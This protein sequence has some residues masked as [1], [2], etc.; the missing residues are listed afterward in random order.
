MFL[1]IVAIF[2]PL[3]AIAMIPKI[4]KKYS[5]G[6]G[7]GKLL[8][9][10]GALGVG[11]MA[12]N[13]LRGSKGFQTA[14][15]TMATDSDSRLRRA[16][17]KSGLAL[18]GKNSFGLG[19]KIN[20]QQLANEKRSPEQKK[21]LLESLKQQ[22]SKEY[23][24][25]LERR[26]REKVHA[27]DIA[28]K[29]H[30]LN[31]LGSKLPDEIA[32]P[33]RPVT[34]ELIKKMKKSP[35]YGLAVLK[36]LAETGQEDVGQALILHLSKDEDG[37]IAL[38]NIANEG[39][40]HNPSL[41]KS[42]YI[43]L[44]GA[45]QDTEKPDRIE[46][47]DLQTTA[48]KVQEAIE[49]MS[50]NGVASNKKTFEWMSKEQSLKDIPDNVLITIL[51]DKTQYA[52]LNAKQIKALE[53]AFSDQRNIE[54]AQAMR[55]GREYR[56]SNTITI[57]RPG[58]SSQDLVVPHY[59]RAEVDLG[60]GT[61]V[62][63]DF[64][65]GL[66]SSAVRSHYLMNGAGAPVIRDTA[67]TTRTSAYF[68]HILENASRS[69]STNQEAVKIATKATVDLLHSEGSDEDHIKLAMDHNY[70]VAGLGMAGGV[71]TV[72]AKSSFEADV[73]RYINSTPTH[74]PTPPPAPPRPTGRRFA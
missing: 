59:D 23:K 37:Q 13:K 14:A 31:A 68:N 48:P 16:I 5:N 24:D 33:T 19:G 41:L 3:I 1:K 58:G 10:A 39:I 66:A 44:Y 9:S 57:N 36:H 34:R 72:G 25:E 67:D 18:S 22:G 27:T 35:E 50:A 12:F 32:N 56:S 29:A 2:I 71:A 52:G 55:E 15:A 8:G 11:A 63:G 54:K 73:Q 43:N 6:I 7:M 42:S 69:G 28:L 51:G 47:K 26:E 60:G 21:A 45:S 74:T 64:M 38:R 30:Q 53:G 61:K 70:H 49:G 40:S 4:I 46:E 17:G 62:S 20:A 65:N